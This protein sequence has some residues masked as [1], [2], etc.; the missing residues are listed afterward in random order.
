MFWVEDGFRTINKE[1]IKI[2]ILP[3]GYH[4][5][6]IFNFAGWSCYWLFLVLAIR[7]KWHHTDDISI[8]M[9]QRLTN[10]DE[11]DGRIVK[12]LRK[13]L[14]TLGT[15]DFQW[16]WRLIDQC[17]IIWHIGFSGCYQ[18]KHT[19]LLLLPYDIVRPAHDCAKVHFLKKIKIFKSFHIFK[20]NIIL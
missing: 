13:K 15:I 5:N 1:A 7:W 14:H 16:F 3:P 4:F 8:Q 20:L 18:M 12:L 10:A 19:W 6:Q 17:A 11:I 9:W 2:Y